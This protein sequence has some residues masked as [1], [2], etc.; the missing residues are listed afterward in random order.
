MSIGRVMVTPIPTPGPLIAPM[1]GFLLSKMRR[2]TWP[3]P[4]RKLSSK[5]NVSLP[6]E[7]SAPAQNARPAPVTMITRTSSSV[8]AFSKASINSSRMIGVKAFSFS[9]R[10]RVIVA[11]RASTSERMCW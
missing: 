5:L 11:T 9:G 8:S 10:F 3:P 1:T 6:L 7:R 2:V 4:S